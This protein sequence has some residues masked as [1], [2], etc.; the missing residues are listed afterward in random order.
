MKEEKV[1]EEKVKGE[2]V[3]EKPKELIEKGCEVEDG[4]GRR[5]HRSQIR[6]RVEL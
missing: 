3:K 2:K 6:Q 1:K 4:K 5:M